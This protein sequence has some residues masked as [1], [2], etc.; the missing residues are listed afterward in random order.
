MRDSMRVMVIVQ[1][2]TAVE[3]PMGGTVKRYCLTVGTGDKHPTC[4]RR[5]TAAPGEPGLE[6]I[7]PPRRPGFFRVLRGRPGA[8]L[9]RQLASLCP[10]VSK[11]S[12]AGSDESHGRPSQVDRTT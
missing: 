11:W 9:A 7:G 6:K 3:V 2:A 8:A 4:S 1:L 12:G 5:G 10:G